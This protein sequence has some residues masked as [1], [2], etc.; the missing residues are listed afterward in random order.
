MIDEEI[1]SV[2]VTFELRPGMEGRGKRIFQAER[3]ESTKARGREQAWN[4][5]ILEENIQLGRV[6]YEARGI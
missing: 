4:V 6:M 3:I 1:F 5:G 2:E